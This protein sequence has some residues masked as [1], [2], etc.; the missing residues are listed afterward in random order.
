MSIYEEATRSTIMQ[1]MGVF[2]NLVLYDQHVSHNSLQ[3]IVAD[4][5]TEWSWSEDGKELT[6]KLRPGVK[7]HD[8]KPFTAADVKCTWDLDR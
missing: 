8:G 3:S 4:L 6:F 7:W 2:N 5:A 1:K